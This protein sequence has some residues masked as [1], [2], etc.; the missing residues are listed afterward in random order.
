MV[1]ELAR[2]SAN[3]FSFLPRENGN[4]IS[5][6]SFRAC[7]PRAKNI[8]FFLFYFPNLPF[9]VVGNSRRSVQFSKTRFPLFLPFLSVRNLSRKFAAVLHGNERFFHRRRGI[10][11][12]CRIELAYESLIT[13]IDRTLWAVDRSE[14][15]R[16]RRINK[17]RNRLWEYRTASLPLGC[18]SRRVS[19]ANRTRI[20]IV[21]DNSDEIH[22]A[23][24]WPVLHGACMIFLLSIAPSFPTKMKNYSVD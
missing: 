8:S 15:R 4:F 19:R 18:C 22:T 24:L 7:E 13:R 16:N 6:F 2:G 5:P 1:S 20:F 9:R 3:C 10:D 17:R 12:K 11:F 14:I 23:I 21:R